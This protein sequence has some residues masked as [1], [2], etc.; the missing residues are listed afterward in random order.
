MQTER[1]VQKPASQP[2]RPPKKTFVLAAIL[3]A[4][5]SIASYPVSPIPEN[6]YAVFPV[7]RLPPN[8][9]TFCEKKGGICAPRI[10]IREKNDLKES[11]LFSKS[12]ISSAHERPAAETLQKLRWIYQST[13]LEKALLDF[14]PIAFEL[15]LSPRRK[16]GMSSS[17]G[18]QPLGTNLALLDL[19]AGAH[20]GEDELMLAHE[21][22]HYLSWLGSGWE[23]SYYF[24]GEKISTM[25]PTWLA[26]G[27]TNWAACR[28]PGFSCA[29]KPQGDG[30]RT[31]HAETYVS[32]FLEAL[33]GKEALRKALLSGDF[34]EIQ[35]AFDSRFGNGSFEIFAEKD[36]IT[37][38]LY[39][40][41]I[42]T[43]CFREAKLPQQNQD[44]VAADALSFLRNTSQ[45]LLE[46]FCAQK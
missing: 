44:A 24:E 35:S 4:G 7:A 40:L 23:A 30:L 5:L 13:V 27:L 31:Y 46:S 22:I 1:H 26:E 28:T 11:G 17:F 14:P 6:P 42:K 41:A 21:L 36:S 33:S 12:Q 45:M 38:A 32:F 25:S 10:F 19:S 9:Y 15:D 20:P 2:H 39:F 18:E 16:P 8:P 34:T 29:L 43:G 37:E 3:A